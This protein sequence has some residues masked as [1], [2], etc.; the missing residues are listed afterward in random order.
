[1]V[2]ESG[3]NRWQQQEIFLFST[4]SR[5]GIEPTQCPIQWIF[6]VL[7]GDKTSK[8]I[9]LFIHLHLVPRFQNAWNYTTTPRYICLIKY[10]LTSYFYV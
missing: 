9:Q 2:K 4:A 1:M 3:F 5:L 7:L 6:G 10:G 8:T